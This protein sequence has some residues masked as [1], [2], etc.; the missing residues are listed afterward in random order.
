LSMN[1]KSAVLLGV[2]SAISFVVSLSLWVDFLNGR[3]VA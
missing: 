1:K 3:F 2:T